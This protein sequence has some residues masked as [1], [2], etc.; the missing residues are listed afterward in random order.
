MTACRIQA[1]FRQTSGRSQNMPSGDGRIL[2]T[3]ASLWTGCEYLGGFRGGVVGYRVKGG[4]S[5]MLVWSGIDM[6]AWRL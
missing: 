6:S 2:C 4:S 1:E 3:I 5:M